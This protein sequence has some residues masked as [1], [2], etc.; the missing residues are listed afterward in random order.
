MDNYYVWHMHGEE[1][2]TDEY[3][4]M[5]TDRGGV[6]EQVQQ[7]EEEPNND[8][9][10]FFDML[11]MAN[12]PIYEGCKQGQ[13]RLSLASRLMSM[14]TDFNVTENCMD[15]FCKKLHEYLPENNQ[16]PQ[17]YYDTKAILKD[18]GIPHEKIDVC[19]NSCMLFL[20]TDKDLMQF[21][22]CGANR[23]RPSKERSRR[24][25]PY[26]KML[27]LPVSYRLRRIYE[28][29]KTVSHMRWHANHSSS[30]K[31]M[32]H[33]FDGI[34]WKD[35]N[36]VFPDFAT[37]P[38]NVYLCLCTDGLSLYGQSDM[39]YSLWSVILSPYNLPPEM[40]L[41]REFMFLTLL[42]PE[43]DH[44]KKS[45]DVFLQPLIKELTDLWS[46]G[47][48]T[49]DVSV[50]QNFTLKTMLLWTISDFPAYDRLPNLF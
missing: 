6:F 39:Q 34:A 28:S 16:A 23:Y 4:C 31:D 27:Y 9:K 1:V 33:P 24:K 26:K 32:Q 44:L 10:G 49:Y 35:F 21:K 2:R 45:F 20:D 36:K 47:V 48:P 14:K 38:R 25:V 29:E 12:H 17:S 30:T 18:L 3:C 11:T 46:I 41:K 43:P 42:I 50:K 7:Q 19:R 40:C 8:A 5:D 15:S 37:E 22:F 13:S